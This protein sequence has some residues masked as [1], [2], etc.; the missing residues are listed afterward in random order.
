LARL[1]FHFKGRTLLRPTLPAV[2]EPGCGNVG[3]PEP[4]LHLGD[5]RV[6]RQ[7]IRGGRGPQGM[8]AEAVDIGGDADLLAV[9]ADNVRVDRIWTQMEGVSNLLI[10]YS[11]C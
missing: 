6:V 4:L 3:M 1:V 9:V 2:I 8:D 11:I 5:V 7:S 10:C